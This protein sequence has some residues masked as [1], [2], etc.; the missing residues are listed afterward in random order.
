MSQKIPVVLLQSV[1]ALGNKD[2]IVNV[3][4]AYAKNVLFAQ[5]KAKPADKAALDAMQQKKEKQAKQAHEADASFAALAA[6]RDGGGSIKIHK[7]ATPQ[8]HLYEKISARDIVT[9]LRALELNVAFD[10]SRIVLREKIEQI[11]ESS[12]DIVYK[13]KKITVPVSVS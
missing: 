5:G 3:A 12:F 10:S 8:G 9:A 6:R 1:K 2:D 11:G 4:I 13:N 7:K